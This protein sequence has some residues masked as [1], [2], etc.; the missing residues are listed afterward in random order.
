MTTP[1][2]INRRPSENDREHEQKHEE[3]PLL[4]IIWN[5]TALCGWNCTDCCVAAV[6]VR[7]RGEMVEIS[8]PELDRYDRLPRDRGQGS[9]FDQALRHRQVEGEELRLEQKLIVLDHLSGHRVKVDISGGD[10]LSPSEGYRLLKAAA[11]R[12]GQD[13]VTL[14]A[15]GA[16]LASYDVSSIKDLIGELNFT[17]D[18]APDPE[19]GLRPAAYASGNLRGARRFA[20]VGVPV[21]AECPLSVQNADP[22]TLTTIYTDLHHAGV[23]KL[24]VMRLFPSGRGALRPEDIPSVTQYRQAIHVLRDLEARYG[25]PVVKLQ[26]ALRHIEGATAGNPCDAVT[27]SFGL[28]WDGT[29]LGSPWAIDKSG[30][31]VDDAWVLG[32][33]VDST[34]TEVLA[35][36]KVQRMRARAHENTG[37]CK[38]FAWV[39]G[40]SASSEDR[41]FEQADPLYIRNARMPA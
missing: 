39:G 15:T 4:D 23:D 40:S 3:R 13:H 41:I 21:R 1:T 28:L 11:A 10:A 14:T 2:S 16:G 12:L 37:H 5:H 31:P 35:T 17:Y 36:E 7:R 30:R 9:I 20:E 22:A 6:H 38:F 32:N 34:L 18:G 8:T 27:E 33:L 24:L 29:L 25:T 19:H 26:C